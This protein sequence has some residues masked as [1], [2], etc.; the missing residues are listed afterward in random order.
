MR[1][2][3]LVLAAFFALF[4]IFV[5]LSKPD[6]VQAYCP[7]GKVCAPSVVSNSPAPGTLFTDGRLNNSDPWETSAIYCMGDGSVRVYVIGNPW[8]IAFTA[9]PDAIINSRGA[10]TGGTRITFSGGVRT[11]FSGGTNGI[12]ISGNMGA[13]L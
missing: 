4:V 7:I 13:S 9:S 10:Y 1:R 3:L 8:H 6:V 2:R 11:T 5:G 12:L